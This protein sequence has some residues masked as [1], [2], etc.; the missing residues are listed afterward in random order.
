MVQNKWLYLDHD[1]HKKPPTT[2]MVS[3]EGILLPLDFGSRIIWLKIN[4]L[5]KLFVSFLSI[6]HKQ[7]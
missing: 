2:W 3:K 1:T 6:T 7:K 5:P 4:I